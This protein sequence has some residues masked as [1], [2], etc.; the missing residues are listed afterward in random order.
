MCG[1]GGNDV[2][3]L[4]QSDVGIALLA[5][6]AN[7]NTAGDIT[8]GEA[9]EEGSA[10]DALNAH[11]KSVMSKWEEVNK[12]RVAHMKQWQAEYQ[13]QSQRRLQEETQALMARG[14]YMATFGAMKKNGLELRNAIQAE[15]T[16]FMKLHGQVWDSKK[17]TSAAGEAGSLASLL[18]TPDDAAGGAA[19]L[20]EQLI[21]CID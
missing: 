12:L 17:D 3:A 1:D 11:S 18:D 19:P 9:R 14:E 5:G 7:T 21:V 10:E 13:K 20:A 6:H 4:K 16:R 2:G 15:N 8:E